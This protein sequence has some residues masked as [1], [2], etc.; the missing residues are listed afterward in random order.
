MGSPMEELT[1]G[2]DGTMV[3]LIEAVAENKRLRGALRAIIEH[4]EIV[5]GKMAKYSGMVAIAK[6]A[7][8]E[9]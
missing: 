4:V 2:T 8:G 9:V 1:D 7:I 3:K 6:K 5:G